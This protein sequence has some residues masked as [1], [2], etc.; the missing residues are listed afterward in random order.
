MFEGGVRVPCIVS[1]PELIEPGTR[2]D[3]LVHSC[4]FYPTL[5]ELLEIPVPDSQPLDG[6]TMVDFLQGVNLR[7]EPTFVY[8]PHNPPVPDWIPP[9]ISVH[10]GDWKLIRI[11][12]GGRDGAHRWMLFDLREDIGETNN[13]A[14]REPQRVKK[15]D[16]MIE[17]FLTDTKAVVPVPNPDFDPAAYRPQ[18]IGKPKLR[19]PK[20]PKP[21]RGRTGPP[22]KPVAGWTPGGDASL[23]LKGGSLLVTSSGRDPYLSHPLPKP[24]PAGRCEV[25]ATISSTGSGRGQLFW[26]EQGVQP[27]FFRERSVVF[28]MTHDGRP[29]EYRIAF[30]SAHPV[31]AIRLDPGQGP[32]QISITLVRLVDPGNGDIQLFD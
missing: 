21:R 12:H 26:Q 20:A 17:K 29:H 2:N 5:L 3:A 11:F 15:L 28:D 13:L 22:A 25:L 1:W 30:T 4:D 19:T 14:D 16:A 10:F 18:D 23:T 32:G 8:F 24:A 27:P 7:C 6:R 31:T 9:A